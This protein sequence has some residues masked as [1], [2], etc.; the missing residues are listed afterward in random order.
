MSCPS[1]TCLDVDG[2]RGSDYLEVDLN[3]HQWNFIARKT[4]SSMRGR[5]HVM[6][7]S[8]AFVVQGNTG[9]ADTYLELG[10]TSQGHPARR[11]ANES[12]SDPHR[13]ADD[14]LPEVVLCCARVTGLDM[15]DQPRP[16][17]AAPEEMGITSEEA[18]MRRKRE[19]HAESLGEESLSGGQRCGAVEGYAGKHPFGFSFSSQISSG[20]A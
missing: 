1:R 9:A 17:P 13:F 10:M 12:N 6:D 19:L 14:Q 3:C 4:L 5:I 11:L 18:L 16:A 2:R 7:S 8:H 20:G 15:S